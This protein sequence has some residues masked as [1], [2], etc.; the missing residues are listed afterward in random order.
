MASCY[1]SLKNYKKALVTL[2]LAQTMCEKYDPEDKKFLAKMEKSIKSTQDLKE[3]SSHSN[4]INSTDSQALG[5]NEKFPSA[6]SKF[7]VQYSPTVGRYAFAKEDIQVGE[8]ILEEKPY[9]TFV[10]TE[11]MGTFC[12]HCFSRLKA[13]VACDT[14]AHVAF[15]SKKCRSDADKYHQYEC[16]IMGLLI[17]SGMSLN[18]YLA[19]RI[20]T[21]S[22]VEEFKEVIQN[23]KH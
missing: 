2:K 17:G 7:D 22:T 5:K 19:L 14:C 3:E 6:S 13:P 4:E 12:S 9:A 18:C 20:I 8:E 23:K 16:R 15:C 21:Q 1:I 11:K 10:R